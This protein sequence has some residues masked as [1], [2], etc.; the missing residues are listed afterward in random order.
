MP[1]TWR[2]RSRCLRWRPSRRRAALRYDDP[3]VV[4]VIDNSRP[5][6]Y[7][8]AA[9]VVNDGPCDVVSLQHEFGL[10]P[11]EWGRGVLEFVRGCRKPIVTTFHTLLT[12]PDPLPRR[13]IRNLAAHS[14]GIVVMTKVAAQALGSVYGVSGPHVQVIPHGVPVVPFERDDSHK[15]RLGLGPAGDLHLRTHQSRQGS[16]IH[17]PGHAADRGRLSRRPSI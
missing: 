4:H 13:S 12:Q 17:D 9:E 5:D 14:Q 6:A 10:Y 2:R 3:R 7:R 11:G 8:L 16:G 1:W 15:A